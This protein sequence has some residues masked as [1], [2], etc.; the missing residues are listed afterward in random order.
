MR[1][2][3][4]VMMALGLGGVGCNGG[5]DSGGECDDGSAVKVNLIDT[6]TGNPIMGTISWTDG[7]GGTGSLDCA[8]ACEFTPASGSVSVTA[9]PSDS[10][11]GDAQ[12]ESVV[13]KHSEDCSEAV[14][15]LLSFEW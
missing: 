7:Q 1:Q 8:G 11:V 12:T 6:A 5:K 15:A 3:L 2:M 13:F 4:V 9:T 14:Y 10:A